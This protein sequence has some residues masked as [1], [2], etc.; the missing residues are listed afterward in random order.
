[1]TV[2]EFINKVGFK[3]NETDVKK[4]NNTISSIKS[5]ATKVL[6]VIGIGFSLT[7]LNSLA[8]EFDGIGDRITYAAEGAENLSEIQNKILEG[9]NNCKTAYGTMANAV[10]ALKQANST[11]FPLEEATT[12][13]EYVNKLG[14]AA[15]YSD[16]EI[17]TMQSN[18]KRI[19]ASGTASSTDITRMLR[20]TP[21]LAEQL[22]KALGTDTEGLSQMAAQGQITAQTLKD[23]MTA[24]A[25]DIDAAY[26]NLNFGVSD[27]LLQIRNKFGFWVDETNKMFNI[28]QT[29]AKTMVSAFDKIKAVLDKARSGLKWLADNLG[30]TESMFRIVAA[31]AAGIM[32]ALNADKIIGF[33][34]TVESLLASINVGTL[35][36]VAAILIIALLIDDLANF[37]QGNDSLIGTF[38]EKASINAD[39]FKESLGGL[40]DGIKSL[41]PL[42]TDFA[43]A[44]GSRLVEA[45][46]K[47]MPYFV[48]FVQNTLP[49]MMDVIGGLLGLLLDLGGG[50]LD[51]VIG[52]AEEILPILMELAESALPPILDLIQS[53][54]PVVKRF[55]ESIGG[56][57]LESV[58]KILPK[59]VE[60]G[61]KVLP[62]L[63]NLFGE[64]IDVVLDLAD[65]GL[66]V[67]L[68]AFDALAP[69]LIQIAEELL[70]P[71]LSL[72]ESILPLI[73][74]VV[75][76][77]LPVLSELLE[78]IIPPIAEIIEAILPVII[79]LI[80]SLLPLITQIIEAVL[81]VVVSLLEAILP[82]ITQIIESVLPVVI[83]LIEQIMPIMQPIFDLIS[84]IVTAIMPVLIS[85][86]DAI[87]PILKP[88]LAI[89]EP[90][91]DIL[92]VIIGA[93]A[94]VVGW[95]ASGLGWIVK[96]IFGGGDDSDGL[97]TS[98]ADKVNS[99]SGSSSSTGTSS[100][101]GRSTASASAYAGGTDYTDDTFVAGEEGPEL[102]TG[103]SGKKV[104]T[105]IQT[106]AIFQNLAKLAALA[107][108]GDVNPATVSTISN[109]SNV[110]KSI[111]QNNNFSNTFNG[112]KTIQRQAAKTM[113]KSSGDATAE[114][115][116]ALAYAR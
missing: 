11:V 45:A 27:A 52:L 101:G 72:I 112:D 39:E 99:Y 83:D 109:N 46:I 78:A 94:K 50:G 22:A 53:I 18:I 19:V 21:A 6:G 47:V 71:L 97:D 75:Q 31:A 44:I 63:M 59:L 33:L 38:L 40:F 56:R 17:S 8:E 64:L 61:D 90:I 96:K 14:K 110:S 51:L 67:L 26:A 41:L 37:I 108:V 91:A 20:S 55:A 57:L 80:E 98:G 79:E 114:L 32:I 77:V 69:I 42:L 48:D 7:Q 95:V 93:I 84:S 30:G 15:G 107:Q 1:L 102:I 92:G 58:Q 82:L 70:P 35:S 29:L 103:A 28:T 89:L 104:F 24:S 85:L 36:L 49:Q 115:A 13:V 5:T 116:R 106:G 88:I 66:G 16:G 23:A 4:V 25:D 87:L 65:S 62:P 60:F 12:F 54:S 113:E 9:A 43:K 34:E 100:G 10:T 2:S 111:V 81:P 76:S 3:V 73:L 105:A 68:E 86:L 74:E